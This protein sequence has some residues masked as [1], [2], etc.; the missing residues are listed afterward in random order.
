MQV[1]TVQPELF[2][3]AAT[4]LSHLP[5]LHLHQAMLTDTKPTICLDIT[6]LR[7]VQVLFIE[8]FVIPLKYFVF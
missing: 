3:P 2:H 5:P 4:V 6:V 1:S 7:I 8:Y